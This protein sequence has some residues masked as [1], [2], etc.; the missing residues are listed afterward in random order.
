MKTSTVLAETFIVLLLSNY[1]TSVWL[2]ATISETIFVCG[3]MLFL[4]HYHSKSCFLLSLL[5]FL[6]L[7]STPARKIILHVD[8]SVRWWGLP[9]LRF[10][11]TLTEVFPYFFLICKANARVKLAKTGH[12]PHSSKLVVF[13]LCYILFACKCVLYYCHRVTTQLQ[14]TC[15]IYISYNLLVSSFT[16]LVLE[17][18]KNGERILSR[19]IFLNVLCPKYTWVRL[20][21]F[22]SGFI[23]GPVSYLKYLR[24]SLSKTMPVRE[25]K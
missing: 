11:F 24:G 14:L 21:K 9:W 22:L 3:I 5:S 19:L 16:F 1:T 17:C 13:V 12:G 20:Y 8:V 7:Q 18:S 2:Y 6:T 10:F 23:Y 15:I 4:F 25:E